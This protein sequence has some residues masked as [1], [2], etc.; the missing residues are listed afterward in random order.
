MILLACLTAFFLLTTF[1]LTVT[2]GALRRLRRS[3]SEKQLELMGWRFY[4]YGILHKRFP[5]RPFDVLLFAH[6][7]ARGISRFLYTAL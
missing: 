4:Y 7:F 1:F 5:K 2:G 3:R 6:V